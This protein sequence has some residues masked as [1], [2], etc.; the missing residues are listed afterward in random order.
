MSD[1]EEAL[2]L[3][4]SARRDLRA[5]E[6]MM[7]PAIVAD[8]IFGFHVQ[9]AVEKALKAWLATFGV[10]YPHT[11][12]IGILLKILETCGCDV[13]GWAAVVR[14]NAFAVQFRYSTYEAAGEPIDRNAAHA[15]VSSVVKD[16]D[17]AIQ[18]VT[19]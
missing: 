8:E 11:H 9:Q 15:E 7:N 17:A 14:W 12:D 2:E 16:V 6:A 19:T 5:L 4:A 1:N 13:A 18:A 10:E 3:L